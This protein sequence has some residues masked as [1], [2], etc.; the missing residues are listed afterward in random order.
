MKTNPITK[1]IEIAIRRMLNRELFY[2]SLVVSLRH[3]MS[4]QFPTAATDGEHVFYNPTFMAQWSPDEVLTIVAHEPRHVAFLHPFRRGNRDPKLW[5]IAAD[6]EVNNDL[7]DAG[8]KPVPQWICDR[9][10]KGMTAEVIYAD[11]VK[12]ARV[13]PRKRPGQ[14]PKGEGEGKG[15]GSGQPDKDSDKDGKGG[16]GEPKKDQKGK[17]KGQAPSFKPG[18][19]PANDLV[20]PAG[21]EK[22][23]EEARKKVEEKL[24]QAALMVT[25]MHGDLPC[26]MKRLVDDLLHPKQDWKQLLA[27][28]I[29]ARAKNDTSWN[30]PSR[31]FL[32]QGVYLPSLDSR[33]LGDVYV[34][35]DTSGS[36]D[37]RIFTAFISQVQ[38]ILDSCKP[39][40]LV[41]VQC[42]ACIGDW[43]EIMEGDDMSKI[44][45]TGG[46]GTSFI[47]PFERIAK[48]AGVPECV[49][50]FTDGYGTFPD[51]EPFYPVFWAMTTDV[52]APWG[53]TVKITEIND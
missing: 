40:K 10:Y 33:Q 27:E 35:V 17:G 25:R 21:G 49:I 18:E 3:G 11:L 8:Y 9:K 39:S 51:K 1:P 19:L 46:G 15:E 26:G 53:R 47:P 29:T 44:E 43:R 6:H 24:L 32:G 23:K 30:R 4:D 31:R 37:Q 14:G 36:I 52:K 2:G 16:A 12:D 34:V 41:L 42:D 48:E 22:G 7:L 5:N 38:L 20:E 28:F 50:Y 45:A 13:N